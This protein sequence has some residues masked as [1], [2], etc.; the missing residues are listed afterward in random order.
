MTYE[1]LNNINRGRLKQGK[2][3]LTMSEAEEAVR[4]RRAAGAGGLPDSDLSDFLV[5]YTL[6]VPMPSAGGMA[7]F[8]MHQAAQPAY[9]HAGGAAN[10]CVQTVEPTPAPAYEPS[11]SSNDSGSSYDSSSS[12]DS[13]SS[14]GSCGTD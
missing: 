5:G 4:K 13:G 2:N 8:A 3:A 7:G 14:G 12:Y 11:P 9:E 10:E 6:G 1:E